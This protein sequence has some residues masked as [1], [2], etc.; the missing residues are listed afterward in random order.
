MPGI[1]VETSL[2][3]LFV[4]SQGCTPLHGKA[5][6][7][8]LIASKHV[9]ALMIVLPAHVALPVRYFP[10]RAMLL[11]PPPC[12]FRIYIGMRDVQYVEA[13]LAAG[14]CVLSEKPIAASLADARAAVAAYQALRNTA[15]WTIAENYRFEEAFHCAARRVP[16]IGEIVKVDM[17]VDMGMR[18]S[19]PCAQPTAVS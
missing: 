12:T 5:G 2:N 9:L 6:F 3:Q 19:N 4:C 11:S 1:A 17:V 8:E 7:E 14:K 13:A 10:I 15:V 18:S 16:K